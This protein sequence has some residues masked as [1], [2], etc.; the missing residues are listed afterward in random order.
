VFFPDGNTHRSL[1][2]F[3]IQ[4]RQRG[5]KS[6]FAFLKKFIKIRLFFKPEIIHFPAFL[7]LEFI[8]SLFTKNGKTSPYGKRKGFA[9][10]LRLKIKSLSDN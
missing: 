5:G 8:F 6:A 4:N 7:P 10:L 1:F 2:R 3:L 9:V